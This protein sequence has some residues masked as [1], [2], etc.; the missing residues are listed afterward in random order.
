MGN[1]TRITIF[2]HFSG[3]TMTASKSLP[4]PTLK[5]WAQLYTRITTPALACVSQVSFVFASGIVKSYNLGFN[6]KGG[7]AKFTI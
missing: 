5:R 1:L 7:I 6:V 4:N 2:K 3:L